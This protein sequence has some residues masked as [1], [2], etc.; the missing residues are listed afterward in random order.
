MDPLISDSREF[1]RGFRIRNRAVFGIF[2]HF[3]MD[4]VGDPSDR[5]HAVRPGPTWTVAE[6]ASA[7]GMSRP[8]FAA[9]FKRQ[10]GEAR[11]DGYAATRS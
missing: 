10:I 7:V 5:P 8:G 1:V 6:L 3:S 9:S 4:S 11:A 2:P